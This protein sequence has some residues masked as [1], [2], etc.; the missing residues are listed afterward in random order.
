MIM[1][2]SKSNLTE[3]QLK[4]NL[5]TNIMTKIMHGNVDRIVKALEDNP[6]LRKDA[7][8]ADK[9]VKKLEKTIKKS[10]ATKKA[11]SMAKF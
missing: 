7:I 1:A 6:Q 10:K 9:A 8:A 3:D 2:S 11:M 4:E 5:F